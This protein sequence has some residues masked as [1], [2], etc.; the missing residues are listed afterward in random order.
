MGIDDISNTIIVSAPDSLLQNISE[1]IEQLDRA[2]RPTNSV[3]VVKLD[4][5]VNSV[6]LQKRLAKIFTKPQPKQPQQ[7]PQQ[8]PQPQPQPEQAQEEP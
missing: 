6:D 2:A 7:R 5:K 8:P 4:G 3:Q 1:L